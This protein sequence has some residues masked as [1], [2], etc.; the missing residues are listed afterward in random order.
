LYSGHALASFLPQP[1]KIVC[2]PLLHLPSLRCA[3]PLERVLSCIDAR[4]T[5]ESA[6]QS[7]NVYLVC[8]IPSRSAQH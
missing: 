7:P 3:M 1:E 5:Y 4:A 2:L 8:V 6:L